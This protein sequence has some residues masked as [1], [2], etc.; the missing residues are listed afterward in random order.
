MKN[1]CRWMV[2]AWAPFGRRSE[3]FAR[4][5]G[6]ELRY[7]HYMKFQSP[8]Y[9]PA[10]YILQ[11]ART[12]QVRWARRP[13]RVFVQN[14]PFVCGLVVYLYCRLTGA[15][16]VLDHHSAAFARIWDWARPFQRFL[17]RRAVAN[18][19]TNPHWA[20]LVQ[21]WSASALV[22]RDPLP[23]LES[24]AAFSVEPGFNVVMI[25]T[26]AD[27]EPVEAVVEAARQ[28]PDVHFYITGDIR[29]RPGRLAL[30][31]LNVTFTGFLPEAQYA[32]LLGAVQA[33]L[34]L[35]TRDHTLQGGGY[36]AVSLGKPLVTSGWPYL[37]ELFPQGAVYV[38]NSAEGI[39]AG[40]QA[41]REQQPSLEREMLLWRDQARMEWRAQF[42]RLLE[43]TADRREAGSASP[44]TEGF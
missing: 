14:P 21:A 22:L 35:T 12:L 8:A 41:V 38:S 26:F 37:R 1:G 10:K 25:C 4:E 40:V 7:I 6:A 27:D 3:S 2:V 20:G 36:E 11:A 28:L 34:A 32:G 30:A 24:G 39:R 31:P 9:A 42:A 15:A 18:L 16:F 13:E 33:V 23:H 43:I 17:A 44:A 19:V 5:L 29:R